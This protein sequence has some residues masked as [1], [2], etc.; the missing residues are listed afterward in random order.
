MSITER[1]KFEVL[2]PCWKKYYITIHFLLML[3]PDLQST[4]SNENTEVSISSYIFLSYTATTLIVLSCLLD[5]RPTWICCVEFGRCIIFLI[6]LT[7]VQRN[8]IFRDLQQFV[9]YISALMWGLLALEYFFKC[10]R[11]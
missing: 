1:P 9:F 4:F 6:A 2:I 3:L 10:H 11:G 8:G 5:G 7:F